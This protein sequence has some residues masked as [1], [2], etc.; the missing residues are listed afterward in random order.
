[1]DEDLIFNGLDGTSGAYFVRL[2]DQAAAAQAQ[3]DQLSKAH[4]KDIKA[5]LESESP[6]YGVVRTV[7]DPSDLAQTGWGV[8][9]SAN[10]SG[11]ER[12]AL[13]ELLEFRRA[14]ATR[15]KA[16]RYQEYA[17]NAGYHDGE[18]AQDF[19]RQ[20]ERNGDRRHALRPACS[21]GQDQANHRDCCEFERDDSFHDAL[22]N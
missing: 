7:D 22:L 10:A 20:V 16:E 18:T 14:D 11:G 21:R 13:A 6:S 4:V 8:I 1:M 2:D 12:T 5:R 3:Q 15:V 9:F 17:G 19:L